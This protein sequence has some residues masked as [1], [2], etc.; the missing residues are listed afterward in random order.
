VLEAQVSDFGPARGGGWPLRLSAR[1]ADRLSFWSCVVVLLIYSQGWV[2][3]FTGPQGDPGNSDMIRNLTT[4]AYAIS[5]V[6]AFTAGWRTLRAIV[7]SPLLWALLGLV[8]LSMLWSVDPSTTVRRA[9]AVLL[10]SIAGLVIAS[11]YDW[12]RL[13]AVVAATFAILAV[14]SFIAGAFVPSYGRMTTLFPGAWQGLWN[15]KNALG[16]RMTMGF[17]VLV[18]AA[19]LNPRQRRMWLGFAGLALFLV[20]MSTSKTSLVALSLGMMAVGFIYVVRRGPAYAVAATFIAVT[21]LVLLGFAI[22]YD[23]EVFFKLLGKDATLTGRTAIWGAVLHEIY[24]RPWTGYGYG[25]VWSDDSVWSTLAWIKHIA[26]FRPYHSHE[27]WLNI[28]LDLGYVGLG[29]WAAYYVETWS[30]AILAAYRNPGA[31]FALPIL[32]VYSLVALTETIALVYNDFVW[33]LFVLIAVR[34]AL[35]A[36]SVEQTPPLAQTAA[37]L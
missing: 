21:A 14:A 4:P 13:T 19:I 17:L 2:M 1:V 27:S 30:R 11:R 10:T 22:V 18:A 23:T 28:W 15:E 31:Y 34:L 8:F 5:L 6:L 3:L 25:A 24:L 29:L 20:I 16:D 9:I 12:P 36:R 7:C 33:V 37:A 32:V 35:G 26:K